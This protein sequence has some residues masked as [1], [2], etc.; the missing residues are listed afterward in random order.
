MRERLPEEIALWIGGAGS[1]NLA[2]LPSGVE[3]TVSLDDLNR[4]LARLPDQAVGTLPE[5]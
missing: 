1:T 2:E 4:V 5:P 3:K